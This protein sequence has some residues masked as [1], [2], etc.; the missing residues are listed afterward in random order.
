VCVLAATWW[1]ASIAQPCAAAPRTVVLG[2]PTLEL[3]D[4]RVVEGDQGSSYADFTLRLTGAPDL[5]VVVVYMTED[6]SAHAG[7][8]YIARMGSVSFEPGMFER[9]ISIQVRGDTLLEPNESFALR[10]LSAPGASLPDSMAVCRIVNDEKTTFESASELYFP[11]YYGGTLCTAWSDYDGDGDP[12]QAM[13]A[14]AAQG[15]FVQN[16]SFRAAVQDGNYH[17]VSWCDYDKDGDADIVLLPYDLAT[18]VEEPSG[19]GGLGPQPRMRLLRNDG[20]TFTD[21][22]PLHGM[23]LSGNG[24]TAVWADFDGDGWPD[25]FAPFY[26]HVPPYRSYLFR[27]RGSGMFESIGEAAGVH[28]PGISSSLKPEGAHAVDWDDDGDVDL[29]CAS[30]LFINDGD[31]RFTDR[32]EEVGLPVVFDEGSFFFDADN[33]GD[34]DLFLRTFAGPRL[35]R[36]DGGTYVETTVESGLTALDISWGDNQGDVDNDGDV[37]IVL[38]GHDGKARMMLN[39]G[40]GTFVADPQIAGLDAFINMCAFADIDGDGDLDIAYDGPL[41]RRVLWNRLD[42]LAGAWGSS[43]RVR[44]LDWGESAT[45]FSAT[46]RLHGP[47]SDTDGVQTRS[48]DGGSGYCTQ[49]DYLVHFGGVGAGPL[50]LEVSYPS[51][52]GARVAL[53]ASTVPEMGGFS[54]G[55]E[56]APR[57]RV[58]QDG[59]FEFDVVT[60]VGVGGGPG[61]SASRIARVLPTPARGTARFEIALASA[62]RAEIVIHDVRGRRVRRLDLGGLAAGDAIAPWDLRDEG[63][64][65][66]APGVYLCGLVVGG[67]LVD[68]RRVPVIE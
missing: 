20:G 48:V 58:C 57:F 54:Q 12:D 28:M 29:Y 4:V 64:R 37:D 1:I 16:E 3:G 15:G 44:V 52:P 45:S 36:N 9:T 19:I 26:A 56:F 10:V 32:R 63:G 34:F 25:L 67:R 55:E 35:F 17:G 65:A 2:V 47:W 38:A 27:N 53:D 43:L 39:Q 5:P 49:N 22:A 7:E 62:G 31:A 51:R 59:R 30:H 41:G 14:N 50:W 40:D 24:E 42:R 6:R 8:D 60:P 18:S 61:S 46:V 68:V 23:D 13:Y 11:P 33:D 66:V 21:V